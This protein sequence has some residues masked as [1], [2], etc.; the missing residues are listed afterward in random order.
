MICLRSVESQ[1][2]TLK[3]ASSEDVAKLAKNITLQHDKIA[4]ASNFREMAGMVGRS[5]GLDGIDGL[6]GNVTDLLP[7]ETSSGKQ[8]KEEDAQDDDE[9]EE[10]EEAD[11][12]KRKRKAGW[13]DRDREVVKAHRALNKDFERL[14]AQAKKVLTDW[15]NI[16]NDM[17]GLLPEN[18]EQLQGERRIGETRLSCLK[19]VLESDECALSAHLATYGRDL[20]AMGSSCSTADGARQL[21]LAPP[22]QS[23]AKLHS[24]EHWKEQVAAVQ[25]V[26]DEEALNN[27]KDEC[28]DIKDTIA[29]LISACRSAVSDA[30]RGMKAIKTAIAQREAKKAAQNKGVQNTG[31]LSTVMMSCLRLPCFREGEPLDAVNADLPLMIQLSVEDEEGVL[32]SPA[33]HAFMVAELQEQFNNQNPAQ[34]LDRAHKKFVDQSEAKKIV[35]SRAS[36]IFKPSRPEGSLDAGMAAALD[37]MAIIVGKNTVKCTPEKSYTGSQPLSFVLAVVSCQAFHVAAAI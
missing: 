8:L 36:A 35:E 7:D 20:P 5:R 13:F 2:T 26:S 4:G 33:I 28:V 10:E 27:A 14:S 37:V 31:K 23:Y 17:S 30:N 6:L 29:E 9:K 3:K 32:K 19:H 22:C 15:D 21:G 11:P 12:K 1:G 18:L 25:G 16:Q 24:F 34:R